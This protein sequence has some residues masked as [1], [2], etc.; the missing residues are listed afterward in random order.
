MKDKRSSKKNCTLVHFLLVFLL[1][2]H[3]DLS[4]AFFWVA[5]NELKKQPREVFHKKRN[6]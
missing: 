4:G 6:S 3:F 5:V 1:A 2:G